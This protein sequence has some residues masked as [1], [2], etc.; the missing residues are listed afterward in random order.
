MN[1]L[2]DSGDTMT[3]RGRQARAGMRHSRVMAIL[4]GLF[5]AVTA[6]TALAFFATN[7]RM[8]SPS[9]FSKHSIVTS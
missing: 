3:A 8:L 7:S 9:A 4:M 5:A 1:T 6:A 2:R